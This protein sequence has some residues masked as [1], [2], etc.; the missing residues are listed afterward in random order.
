L[1]GIWETDGYDAE[2]EAE[3]RDYP[4]NPAFRHR[5]GPRGV[6]HTWDTDEATVDPQYG[7]VGKQRIENTGLLTVERMKTID[8]LI[9]GAGLDG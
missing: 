8:A 5:F 6:M 4:K 7:K 1:N 2:E 3:N 9:C